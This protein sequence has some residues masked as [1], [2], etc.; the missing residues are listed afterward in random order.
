RG[1]DGF[2]FRGHDGLDEL[3][4]TT[5][6]QVW[7]IV[8]GQIREEVLDPAA[9]GLTRSV[10]EDLLGGDVA[11]NADTVHRLLA[12]ERGP[13]RDAVLLNAAA[14]LAAY[15][16][17]DAPL[18]QRLRSG[19]ERAEAAIDSGAARRKLAAWVEAVAVR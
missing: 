2:V 5:T 13:V 6:S 8:G 1:V 10:P 7:S 9:L 19:L 3:T 17:T 16:V 14:G 15:D 4:T 11:F 18:V 12:G